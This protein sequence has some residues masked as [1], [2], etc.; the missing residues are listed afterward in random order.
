[1]ERVRPS[2]PCVD[3][4]SGAG[5]AA[6]VIV[7]RTSSF[8]SKHH[9]E[10]QSTPTCSSSWIV[11]LNFT[12]LASSLL[13]SL[14]KLVR[15]FSTTT[16]TSMLAASTSTGRAPFRAYCRGRFR[17]DRPAPW[18]PRSIGDQPWGDL[19]GGEVFLLLFG[20]ELPR[21]Q[22][23]IVNE[24]EQDESDPLHTCASYRVCGGSCTTT[25]RYRQ[26]GRLFTLPGSLT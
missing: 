8:P 20:R 6:C 22:C 23:G 19:D 24:P 13:N 7:P 18:P 21:H 2:Q 26:Y 17:V 12:V 15:L 5:R 11:E 16:S 25:L 14:K 4:E 3:A 1:M 10:S 9:R